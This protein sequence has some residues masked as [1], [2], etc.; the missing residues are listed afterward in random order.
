MC[1]KPPPWKEKSSQAVS[2]A[3]HPAALCGKQHSYYIDFCYSGQVKLVENPLFT[4]FF[5][6]LYIDLQIF[7]LQHIGVPIVIHIS[8][9]LLSIYLHFFLMLWITPYFRPFL[10]TNRLFY[11]LLYSISIVEYLLKKLLS[12]ILSTFFLYLTNLNNFYIYIKI[13]IATWWG[14]SASRRR[15]PIFM[16]IK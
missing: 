8:T 4:G 7:F 6:D 1:D 9:L 13:L 10:F 12:T 14:F 2:P 3:G 15:P 11:C 16:C 5:R